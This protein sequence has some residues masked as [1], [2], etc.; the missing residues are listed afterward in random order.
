M[1]VLVQV[2][3]PC[4]VLR[5][6]LQSFVPSVAVGVLGS[7]PRAECVVGHKFLTGLV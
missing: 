1:H 3:A 4:A 5:H 7:V 6:S 2:A